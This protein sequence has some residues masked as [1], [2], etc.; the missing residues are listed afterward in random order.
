MAKTKSKRLHR[1]N[2]ILEEKEKSQYWLSQET[3]ISYVSINGYVKN[4]I[5]PSL[6]NLYRIAKVLK[7][8]PKD[9]LNS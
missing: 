6:T 9:L 4:R 7:V 1:I 5:E 2:E 3:G 8:N